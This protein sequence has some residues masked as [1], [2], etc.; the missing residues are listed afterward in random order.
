MARNRSLSIPNDLDPKIDD[1]LNKLETT[2]GIN[3]SFNNWVCGLIR[4]EI[5][6]NPVKEPKK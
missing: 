2:L 1:Y 3:V 5:T 4:R 6:T